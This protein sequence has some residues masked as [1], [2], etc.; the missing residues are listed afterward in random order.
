MISLCSKDVCMA[1]KKAKSKRDGARRV[2]AVTGASEHLGKLFVEHLQAHPA[3]SKI[4]VID[5]REPACASGRKTVFCPIDL[6]MPEAGHDL[7]SLFKSHGVDVLVHLA[8]LSHPL[9]DTTYAH[10]LQVIGT[11][12]LLNAAAAAKTPKLVMLGSTM[13]YGARSDNPNF[14][15]ETDTLK[16]VRACPLVSDLVEVEKQFSVFT[17]KHPK[18]VATVLRMGCILDLKVDGFIPRM[19]SQSTVPTL[20]GYDPLMQFLHTSDALEAIKIA[21]DKDFPGAYN[22]VA[23]GVLPLS[24]ILRL[25]GRLSIPIPHC[26]W[27]KV[28]GFLWAFQASS[29]PTSLLDYIRYLWVADGDKARKKMGFSPRFSTRQTLLEFIR[30]GRLNPVFGNLDQ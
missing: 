8:F 4:L 10:E 26:V 27:E 28:G 17:Q 19:L 2:I 1:K 12:H 11:M 25:G 14:L 13:S 7:A 15:R 6:T 22:I 16:G 21:V 5:V 30:L 3:I 24:T 29:T 23:D 9:H 20:M 18:V